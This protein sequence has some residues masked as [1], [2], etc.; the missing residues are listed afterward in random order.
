MNRPVATKL[1]LILTVGLALAG[2]SVAIGSAASESVTVL[3][4]GAKAGMLMS[5]TKS[6]SVAE[7]ANDKNAASLLGVL[8][9]D[10]S[11]LDSQPGQTGV[12]TEGVATT[13]VSTL[14]G[15]IRVGDRI[16]PSSL[17]GIGA[18]AVASGWIVGTAQGSLDAQTSGVSSYSVT[19][20]A[21]RKHQV[22]VGSLPVIIKVTYY[23]QSSSSNSVIPAS[24]QD[25]VDKLAGKH[26][27]PLAIILSFILILIGIVLA[28][29]LVNGSTRSAF[30]AISRQP[31]TKS[32]IMTKLFQMFGI[33][34]GLILL[35]FL[36]SYLIL[37]FL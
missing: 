12:K 28:A 19:D 18:K 36:A 24:I 26:V 32:L 7:P 14:N 2:S 16:A 20:T 23:N 29:Q 17:V 25:A 5:L 30:S 3:D 13:L 34:A 10:E 1:W 27:R 35:A 4:K 33:A 11:S 9:P 8:A 15:D 22:A 6:A 37:R 31:L 21:G